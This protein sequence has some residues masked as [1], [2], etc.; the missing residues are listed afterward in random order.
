MLARQVGSLGYEVMT[1]WQRLDVSQSVQQA[2]TTGHS[3]LR[4]FCLNILK[5]EAIRQILLWRRGERTSIELLSEDEEQ[6][7][8]EKGQ[9]L[10][11][12]R[13]WVMDIIRLRKKEEAEHRAS[14]PLGPRGNQTV[15]RK[16]RTLTRKNYAESD[17]N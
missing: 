16:G 5:Q 4:Q 8:Y 12:E 1:A 7:L 9:E 13:D 2:C 17:S 10:L 15:S 3:P 14:N 6:L 11:E